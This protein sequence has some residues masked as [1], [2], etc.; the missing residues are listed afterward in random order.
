M[1]PEN[2]GGS[3]KFLGGH[4][5][6]HRTAQTAFV[7]VVTPRKNTSASGAVCLKKELKGKNQN[8]PWGTPGNSW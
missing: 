8:N 1:P 2:S 7:R 3:M 4:K 6:I 5:V